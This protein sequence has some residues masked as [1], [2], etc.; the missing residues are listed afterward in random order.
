MSAT[1]WEWF[2]DA[3][4][5]DSCATSITASNAASN[6]PPTLR[7]RKERGPGSA[8][9]LWY[10][11]VT[12]CDWDGG[13][14]SYTLALQKYHRMLPESRLRERQRD[15]SARD[16]SGRARAR[17]ADDSKRRQAQRV[18]KREAERAAGE[19]VLCGGGYHHYML[20]ADQPQ[21]ERRTNVDALL[22]LC[23]RELA[24]HACDVAERTGRMHA[25]ESAVARGV[26]RASPWGAL[27][28][29]QR[30]TTLPHAEPKEELGDPRARAP[31]RAVSCTVRTSSTRHMVR[32]R[33]GHDSG[34]AAVGIEA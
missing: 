7:G 26:C 33:G 29:L 20:G 14:R 16:H 15:R 19:Q 22:Q 27:R 12:G 2:K 4:P 9:A 11:R 10:R 21:E 25:R 5:T 18:A 17:P 3:A 6:R 28:V 23:A 32:C 1:P 31:A 30:F 34:G 24:L 13:S 8:P